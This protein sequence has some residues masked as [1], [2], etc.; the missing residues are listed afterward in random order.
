LPIWLEL[1]FSYLLE[2]K[3]I[4]RNYL[5]NLINNIIIVR[6]IINYHN[7]RYSFKQHAHF[8]TKI[9]SNSL[10]FSSNKNSLKNSLNR[11]NTK[12]KHFIIDKL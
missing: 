9:D 7:K 5:T 1:Q 2:V 10:N 6:I 8:T 12:N 3:P 4:L 11:D